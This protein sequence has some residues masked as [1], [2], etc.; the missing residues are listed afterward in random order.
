[1]G[2][3]INLVFLD[4]TGEECDK[5]K[6]FFGVSRFDKISAKNTEDGILYNVVISSE[7]V[8]SASDIYKII[9]QNP[10]I[11]SIARQDDDF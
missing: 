6:N 3:K 8:I 1:M 4:K 9:E 11:V 2:L 7:T 10:A 5:L